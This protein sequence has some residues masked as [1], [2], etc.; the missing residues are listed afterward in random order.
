MPVEVHY[1]DVVT[2]SQIRVRNE[3]RQ[4][5]T[6]QLKK[7]LIAVNKGHT[8]MWLLFMSK[9]NQLATKGDFR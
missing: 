1:E 6:H 7:S 4:L 5:L 8:T 2:T 9:K 3:K